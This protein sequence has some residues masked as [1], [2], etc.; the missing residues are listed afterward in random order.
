MAVRAAGAAIYAAAAAV[1][2]RG[3]G[4]GAQAPFAARM[5]IFTGVVHPAGEP[6][7]YVGLK[8]TVKELEAAANTLAGVAILDTHDDKKRL[9]TI[10][11]SWLAPHELHP[12]QTVWY[13]EGKLDETAD[14]FDAA[15]RMRAG[16]LRG[17]S[18]GTHTEVFIDESAGTLST[19]EK[20]VSEVS[21]CTLGDRPNT[22]LFINPDWPEAEREAVLRE[23]RR[24]YDSARSSNA[25][26]AA[27]DAAASSSS[28]GS[29]SSSSEPSAAMQVDA[30]A[31]P[32]AQQ[33][34]LAQQPAAPAPAQPQSAPLAQQQAQPAA[35]AY[36]RDTAGA[37]GARAALVSAQA[38]RSAAMATTTTT[39][40]TAAAAG[41]AAMDV[42]G[43][44]GAAAA[45]QQ[46][47][48]PS[49]AME[50]D[51]LLKRLTA[52]ET[53]QAAAAAQQPRDPATGQFMGAPA[54]SEQE[55]EY[56]RLKKEEE[57]RTARK[58]KKAEMKKEREEREAREAEHKSM[59]ALQEQAATLLKKLEA[60]AVR[61]N[62][63][64]DA[65]TRAALTDD[66]KTKPR[67][68][69]ERVV[70]VLAQA[71]YDAELRFSRQEEE[72]QRLRKE[73]A[74][75]RAAASSSSTAASGSGVNELLDRA[76]AASRP[77]A[78]KPAN[79]MEVVAQAAA[80]TIDDSVVGGSGE[81]RVRVPK[82]DL[83]GLFKHPHT[84][85]PMNIRGP[86][87]GLRG[88]RETALATKSPEVIAA[89]N[90][91]RAAVVGQLNMG[92]GGRTQSAR[93]PAVIFSQAASGRVRAT[94]GDVFEPNVETHYG[95]V[96]A[97]DGESHA[98]LGGTTFQILRRN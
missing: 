78:A 36:M 59:L 97:F 96:A 66:L 27:A 12:E 94:G 30:P 18:L 48:Q 57:E 13:V 15:A 39:S 85:V 5:P 91:T 81:A 65:Q 75:S 34:P 20:R 89:F 84:G 76:R 50:T 35:N 17:L 6:E 68:E 90:S 14:G 73:L 33:A 29:S 63:P 40:N 1:Y 92:A 72:V 88:M 9:G 7:G 2:V 86:A 74:D 43:G 95:R 56:L 67:A 71:A 37:G 25:A 24:A 21:V 58:A 64:V 93:M 19:G 61:D 4:G 62:K 28:S 41:G 54:M 23:L 8:H 77:A 80:L 46:Q 32:P 42:D 44:A 52:L 60:M 16:K 47:Q 51:E 26:F 69:N 79:A 31:P 70:K 98:K 22:D 82:P 10:T 49:A 38:S 55:R 3:G 53:R 87:R 11:R 83:A 45:Q